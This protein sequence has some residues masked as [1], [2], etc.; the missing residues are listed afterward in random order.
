MISEGIREQAGTLDLQTDLWWLAASLSGI[1]LAMAGAFAFPESGLFWAYLSAF[2]R[3]SFG[4]G[5]SQQPWGTVFGRLLALGLAA[6]LFSI[7][8]D[9]L[10]VR[11]FGTAQRAYPSETAAVLAT[12][13]YALLMGAGF[14]V[15]AGYAG[16]RVGGLMVRRWPGQTGLGLA[17]LAAGMAAA[18][19]AVGYEFLAVKARWWSYRAGRSVAEEGL[20]AHVIV[21]H[22]FTFL[23]FL[24]L[25]CR[26]A[27][28]PGTRL[29]ATLRYGILFAAL[30]FASVLLSYGLVEAV[31]P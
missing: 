30:S 28:C 22:F 17:M 9:Y 12:P 27:T 1:A 20:A 3:I 31:R 4:V 10:L 24:P 8:P 18:L 26:Y 15:E 23:G 29:Y 21:A 14:V 19:W 7:F 5:L 13:P 2:V 11:G 16:L 25:F 6:A